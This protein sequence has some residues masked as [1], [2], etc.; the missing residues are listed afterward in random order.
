MTQFSPFIAIVMDYVN[1]LSMRMV[2]KKAGRSS[3]TVSDHIHKHDEAVE[4]SG[5]VPFARESSA[6]MPL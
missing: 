3:R 6:S 4:R 2:S 5:S 1:G